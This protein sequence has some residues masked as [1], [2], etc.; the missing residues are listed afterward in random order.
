MVLIIQVGMMA[1]FTGV[2]VMFPCYI[3]LVLLTYHHTVESGYQAHICYLAHT[4][5]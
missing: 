1:N 4:A 5:Y 3:G 2:Q